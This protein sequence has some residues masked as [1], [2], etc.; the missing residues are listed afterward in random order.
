MSQFFQL[1]PENPQE[2]LIRQA[3]EIIRKGGVIAYPTDSGYALG[4]QLADK[5]AIETIKRIRQLD[6]KH[7]FTLVC[8]D[9]SDI[10]N[11]AKVDNAVYRLLKAHTPGAY[12]F[13]LD[14]T[15][16]VPRLLLHPKR[17]S[18]GVRIPDHKITLALL[19]ELGEPLMSTTLILP[20]QELPETDPY[21]IRL[22][23]EHTLDLII[24][25]GACSME[26]TSVVDLRELPP[27]IV[28]EGK[29]DIS[30]FV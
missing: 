16:E 15:T 4:C 1:H 18:I 30:P 29:G 5:K 13:I 20:G 24:D 8:S 14:A 19:A 27:V 10:S 3:V 26:A 11:Y 7:N 2:R 12:T 6:Q 25:G 28:R 21:E 23:L 9:L 17:R 22:Q